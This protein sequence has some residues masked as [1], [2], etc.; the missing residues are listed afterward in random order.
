MNDSISE[1]KTIFFL[2]VMFVSEGFAVSKESKDIKVMADLLRQGATLTE[3]SCPVCSS[4]LFKLR[5]GD[6]WCAS[7]QKRVIIVK[8]GEPEPEATDSTFFT[9]LESTILTKIQEIEKELR[10]EKDVEKM[11]NLGITLSTLLKNL[12][13]IRKMR[14]TS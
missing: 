7:C 14:T 5:S 9:N 10:E 11:Q 13:K 1:S 4:P 6:L 2:D 12:E 8:Q 3:Y